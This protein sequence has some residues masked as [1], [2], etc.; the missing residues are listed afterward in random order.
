ML[1]KILFYW[2]VEYME[3]TIF[4]ESLRIIDVHSRGRKLN[5]NYIELG[6]AL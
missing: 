4:I 3:F 6:G 2:D 5:E 1:I